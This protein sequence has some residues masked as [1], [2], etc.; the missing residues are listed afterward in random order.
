[1]FSL[2]SGLRGGEGA[3][4]LYLVITTSFLF[5]ILYLS[6]SSSSAALLIIRQVFVFSGDKKFLNQEIKQLLLVK[7]M[8]YLHARLVKLYQHPAMLVEI[9]RA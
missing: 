1:M 9:T 7:K 2:R 8:F 3:L 5:I 4:G 6:S